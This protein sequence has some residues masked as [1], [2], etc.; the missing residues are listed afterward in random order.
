MTPEIAAAL[1]FGF[2]AGIA[3]CILLDIDHP[4]KPRKGLPPEPPPAP[5]KRPVGP[6]NEQVSRGGETREKR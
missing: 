3:T 5:P 1:A 6:P 4:A 2:M